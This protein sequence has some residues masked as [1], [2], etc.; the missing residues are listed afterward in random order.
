MSEFDVRKKNDIV[1]TEIVFAN[2]TS[3]ANE[4]DLAYLCRQSDAFINTIMLSDVGGEVLCIQD[5][6]HALNLIKALNK[7]IE[8]GWLK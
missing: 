6:E 8:L 7:A 2:M 1:I 4:F 3:H 5:K